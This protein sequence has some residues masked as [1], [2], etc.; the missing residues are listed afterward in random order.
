MH[1]STRAARED[2][3][4]LLIQEDIFLIREA[5]SRLTLALGLESE[6]TLALTNCQQSA[7]M[8]LQ[9]L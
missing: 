7:T 8:P 4:V 3:D 6:L 1:Q 9:F 2:K 5:S